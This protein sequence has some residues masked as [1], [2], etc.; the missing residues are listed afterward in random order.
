M[1]EIPE[2]LTSSVLHWRGK[3]GAAWLEALPTRIER[4][5]SLWDLHLSEIAAGGE[6]SC[7][8]FCLTAEGQPAVLKIP[9]DVRSGRHESWALKGWAKTGASPEVLKTQSSVGV[10]LMSRVS[11]AQW[12]RRPI[13]SPIRRVS[14]S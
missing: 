5:A 9:R 3:V 12:P 2:L 1:I 6:L 11:R 13:E 4:Y 8:V 10:F 14:A 7:C